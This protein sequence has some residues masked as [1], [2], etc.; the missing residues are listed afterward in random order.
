MSIYDEMADLF[1]SSLAGEMS[2]LT[3]DEFLAKLKTE[4]PDEEIARAAYERLK[5]AAL[6]MQQEAENAAAARGA[7]IVGIGYRIDDDKSQG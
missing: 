2:G 4:W 1:M 7:K 5:R 3:R 6:R